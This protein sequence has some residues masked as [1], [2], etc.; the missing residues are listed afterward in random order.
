MSSPLSLFRKN[1]KLLMAIFGVGLMIAFTVSSGAVNQFV[2]GSRSSPTNPPVVRLKTGDLNETALQNMRYSRL[3][4]Q[5][6]M[7]N[8]NYLSVER[9]A[10]PKSWLGIPD[11]DDEQ[12]LLQTLL[13]S[14]KAREMGIVVTD[15]SIVQ[16][17]EAYSEGK[18]QQGEFAGLL[19]NI[20]QGRM[21]QSQFFNAMRNELL[22]L[23][24]ME[25]FQRGVDPLPPSTSWALFQRL[26]RQVSIEAI[27]FDANNYLSKVGEPTE[28]E[29]VALYEEGKD[30][31]PSPNAAEPGFKRRKKV[32]LQ[33]VKADLQPFL[34]QEKAKITDQA[35][36]EFYESNKQEFRDFTVP[37]QAS[38][39]TGDAP[40]TS[41]TDGSQAAPA[42][43]PT[44]EGT[45]P[46][47]ANPADTSPAPEAALPTAVPESTPPAPSEPAPAQP[48]ADNL[49]PS[50]R[51]L[52]PRPRHRQRL[53][54]GRQPEHLSRCRTTLPMPDQKSTRH[55]RLR[56]PRQPA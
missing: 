3:L 2:R 47:A 22:A 18:I 55:R 13:L 15:E 52:R 29:I 1:Q 33:Y 44:S 5:N 38:P 37:S 42:A 14:N 23:R 20:S 16:Y 45:M 8:V 24:F 40:V 7:R 6:F 35:I 11:A 36:R 53:A 25:L 49:R 51:P 54:M 56:S 9:G 46:P 21:S 10:Q 17:L 30:R 27:A 39:A 4:L 31:Y 12:S 48:P 41:P 19:N 34:D 26:Y 50:K 28:Q 32:A 43:A